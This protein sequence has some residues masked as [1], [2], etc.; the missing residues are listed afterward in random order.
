MKVP[1]NRP[2]QTIRAVF[3]RL[4]QTAT[5]SQVFTPK[6]NK[7]DILKAPAC[8]GLTFIRESTKKP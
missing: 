6:A 8:R 5:I 2:S 1:L 7:L 4:A 3:A